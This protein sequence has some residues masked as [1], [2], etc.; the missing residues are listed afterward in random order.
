MVSKGQWEKLFKIAQFT[1][2]WNTP[3]GF[4]GIPQP[5][6]NG[7]RSEQEPLMTEKGDLRKEIDELRKRQSDTLKQ[8]ICFP[9][10]LEE[11]NSFDERANLIAKLHR[12]LLKVASAA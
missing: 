1:D 7:V 2:C 5:D 4:P 10:T 3:Y 6:C 11:S 9:M 12:E 8:A